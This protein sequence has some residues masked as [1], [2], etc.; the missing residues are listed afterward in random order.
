MSV[1]HFVLPRRYGQRCECCF[2]R[3]CLHTRQLS[4]A[5]RDSHRLFADCRYIRSCAYTSITGVHITMQKRAREDITAHS[6][7]LCLTGIVTMITI[8]DTTE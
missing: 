8:P 7:Y 2:M 1:G 4:H 3:Q 6:E 5:G